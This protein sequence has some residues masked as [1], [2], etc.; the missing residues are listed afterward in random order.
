MKKTGKITFCAIM[1]A[2]SCVFMLTSFFPYMTYGIPAI[3]G[4][5]I[6]IAVIETGK[7][8]GFASFVASVAVLLILPA[9]SEA[10]LLYIMFFGY[11]PVLKALLEDR[12]G[13]VIGYSLKFLVF[14][15]SLLVSYGL[16][17]GLFGIDIGDM[18]EFGKYTGIILLGAANIVF[19]IYDIA[20][21]RM[22]QVY[23]FRLHKPVSKI[24]NKK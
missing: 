1:A 23:I 7:L 18:G 12:F 3:A 21:S 14:N 8:W 2:L 15:T 10:K 11:Y 17:V 19:P 9:D 5:F 6:M 20:V 4:L 22:A 16:L 13:R 24:F